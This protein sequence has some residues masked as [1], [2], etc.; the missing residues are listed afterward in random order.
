MRK[1]A[2]EWVR[3]RW[4]IGSTRMFFYCKLENNTRVYGHFIL[5]FRVSL[6]GRPLLACTCRLGQNHIFIRIYGV[7]TVLLA[8]KSPYIQSY[9]VCIYGSGQPYVYAVCIWLQST[10]MNCLCFVP[11]FEVVAFVSWGGGGIGNT[12]NSLLSRNIAAV[13]RQH[14]TPSKVV[15]NTVLVYKPYC[16]IV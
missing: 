14:C 3:R 12:T 1:L 8:G 11:C 2:S 15:Q 10:H 13:C 6:S 16:L 7:H 5:Y 4:L 9:T